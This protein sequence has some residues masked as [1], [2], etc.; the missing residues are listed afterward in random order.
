MF[1]T[2][3]RRL[4]SVKIAK[5]EILCETLFPDFVKVKFS[6]NNVMLISKG[7]WP[8]RKSVKK[9][10]AKL[11]LQDIPDAISLRKFG[12]YG[13]SDY[14]LNEIHRILNQNFVDEESNIS[15]IIDYLY[16]ELYKLKQIIDIRANYGATIAIPLPESFSIPEKLT[17]LIIGSTTFI[18]EIEEDEPEGPIFYLIDYIR[19]V[20][21]LKSKKNKLKI[22]SFFLFLLLNVKPI[23]EV[24]PGVLRL[25]YKNYGYYFNST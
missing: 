1:K 17:P 10:V 16:L 2:N 20:F 23:A 21:D 18:E 9:S 3:Y 15:E 6:K 4:N 22:V 5:L 24:V 25:V 13:V 8:F 14:Y 12:N 19:S 7:I 11:L